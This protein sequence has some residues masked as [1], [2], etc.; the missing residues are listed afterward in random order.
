M[1]E[2]IKTIFIVA[3]SILLLIFAGIT[4]GLAVRKN[5]Y[6]LELAEARIELE[7]IR[8]DALALTERQRILD[9][10]LERARKIV[11]RQQ[12]SVSSSLGTIQEIRSC[13]AEIRAYTQMLEDC[14][15]NYDRDNSSDNSGAGG[16][17]CEPLKQP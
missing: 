6:K 9:G 11:E 15:R 3:L 7:R 16:D 10:N 12:A 4:G 13:I 8:A 2:K 17:Y 5:Q 1:I 14:L